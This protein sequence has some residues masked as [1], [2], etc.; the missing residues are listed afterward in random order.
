MLEKEGIKF[1]MKLP[2]LNQV[3]LNKV[4]AELINAFVRINS[5]RAMV[6]MPPLEEAPVY[7]ADVPEVLYEDL[8]ISPDMIVPTMPVVCPHIA[9]EALRSAS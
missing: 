8:W 6:G 3:V 4:K 2:G 7:L 1:L 9:R 5:N